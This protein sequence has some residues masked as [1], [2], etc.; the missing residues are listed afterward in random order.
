[1]IV[2]FENIHLSSGSNQYTIGSMFAHTCQTN[3]TS[4]QR[5]NRARVAASGAGNTVRI[6]NDIVLILVTRI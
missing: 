5:L 1:M 6:V 4:Q 3:K 2:E